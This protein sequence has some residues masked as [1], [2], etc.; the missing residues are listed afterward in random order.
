MVARTMEDAIEA[1]ASAKRR[2]GEAMQPPCRPVDAARLRAQSLNVLGVPPPERY[3]DLLKITD[4][5]SENSLHIYA[6]TPGPDLVARAQGLQIWKAGFVEEN[7]DLRISLPHYH[8]VLLFGHSDLYWLVE[9]L[10][11]RI[12]G[13][14]PRDAQPGDYDA[15]LA[16][17]DDLLVYAVTRWVAG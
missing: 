13:I 5:V 4:G 10:E 17:F 3:L 2:F 9:D 14:L 8:R 6:S 12:Y 11:E 7:R 1:V 16:T 15:R